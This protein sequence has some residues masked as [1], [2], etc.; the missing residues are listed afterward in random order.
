M[1]YPND[2]NGSVLQ[3]MRDAGMDM[4]REYPI[5]FW[6]LFPDQESAQA[7]LDELSQIGIQAELFDNSE[8]LDDEDLDY[9]EEIEA[10]EGF[11][12]LCIVPMVPTHEAI[13][14]MESRLG[15]LAERHG[16]SADGWGLYNEDGIEE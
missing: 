7:M 2:E 5:E 6:H 1:E 14:S 8:D 12:V 9:D 13:T 15:S 4:A 10:G 3:S 11:D 16:G